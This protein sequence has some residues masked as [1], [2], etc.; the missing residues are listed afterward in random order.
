M[1]LLVSPLTNPLFY[2]LSG[3][4]GMLSVMTVRPRTRH[5]SIDGL[6][7][8]GA[9]THPGT[10][11]VTNPHRA[12]WILLIASPTPFRVPICLSGA[13][14]TSE[15][16]L[17][18]LNVLNPWAQHQPSSVSCSLPHSDL[19]RERPYPLFTTVRAI[20]FF[21]LSILISWTWGYCTIRRM[22]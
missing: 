7:F 1:F 13:R 10:G 4:Y 15:Q 8:V 5:S 17:A 21:M 12:I 19:D 22:A 3:L 2:V 16:I 14:I 11:Y 18:H 9:S 6:F 20:I